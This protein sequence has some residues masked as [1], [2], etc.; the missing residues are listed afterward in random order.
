M[1]TAYAFW[2]TV[3]VVSAA[4]LFGTGLGIAFFAWFGYRRALRIGEIDGLRSVLSLTVIA[5]TW[6]TAPAVVVQFASGLVLI[7]LNHWSLG[8]SW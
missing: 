3:H 7:Q 6:F 4:I 8:S 2:K 1:I 5:D